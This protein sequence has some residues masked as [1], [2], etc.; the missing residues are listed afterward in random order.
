MQKL[1]KKKL[2]FITGNEGSGTTMLS[3]FL[4]QPE[5]SISLTA[6]SYSAGYHWQSW[7]INS[8]TKKMWNI[9]GKEKSGN[10]PSKKAVSDALLKMV[11]RDIL[12]QRKVTHVALKRSYPFGDNKHFPLLKDLFDCSSWV[13]IL[14]MNRDLKACA[15]SVLRR[16]MVKT[17]KQAAHR[18]KYGRLKLM[19]ELKSVDEKFYMIIS[20]ED[21]IK[22]PLGLCNKIENFIDY[23][24]KSLQKFV[25][26][27]KTANQ[28]SEE[29][30]TKH[31]DFLSR[32]FAKEIYYL[33]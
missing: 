12:I 10:T 16:R 30:L 26:C 6:F 9:E 17:I 22:D 19:S 5:F 28:E 18:V 33:Y 29:I 23:P 27:I 15:A 2:I 1:S 31:F 8:C 7:I 24:A 11:I 14:I 4:S 32:F 3:R 25:K 21:F 20:Y 13:K